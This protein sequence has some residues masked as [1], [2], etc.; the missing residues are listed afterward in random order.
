MAMKLPFFYTCPEIHTLNLSAVLET[1][2]LSPS[3]EDQ[4]R[5]ILFCSKIDH[6]MIT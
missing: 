4:K 2:R 3:K 1:L 5:L 6:E